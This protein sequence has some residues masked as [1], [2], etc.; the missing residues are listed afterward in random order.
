MNPAL[1]LVRAGPA[2]RA[3]LLARRGRPRAGNA[4]DRAVPRLVQRVER[5]L[6]HVDVGPDALLVPVGE[7][8]H[9]P[10]AVAIRP[11]ELRRLRAARRL[12]AADAG[13]PGAVRLERGQQRPDLAEVAAAGRG[14]LPQGRPLA[15][16]L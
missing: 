2:A 14:G 10:H 1:E 6:V 7:G 3:L 15:S 4:A 8:V 13:D 9:L 12:L 5:D 16:V 11:L